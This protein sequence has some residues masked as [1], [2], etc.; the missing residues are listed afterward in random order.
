[1]TLSRL[2]VLARLLL[3]DSAIYEKGLAENLSA[4]IVELAADYSHIMAA[5]SS[6]IKDT[7]PRVTALLDVGQ[8]TEIVGVESEDTFKR[9]I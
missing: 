8:L 2:L 3:A 1:M 9:P 4:L 6:T 7:M 5:A